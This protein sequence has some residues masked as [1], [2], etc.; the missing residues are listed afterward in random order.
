MKKKVH[1]K[2]KT[3]VNLPTQIRVGRRKTWNTLYIP[4]GVNV[5]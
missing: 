1:I 3:L 5:W 4:K 2:Q